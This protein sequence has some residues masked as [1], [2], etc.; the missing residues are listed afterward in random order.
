MTKKGAMN[1][2]LAEDDEND[3]SMDDDA[4]EKD[5]RNTT[6]NSVLE[7]RKKEPSIDN[8]FKVNSN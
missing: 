5:Y 2:Y 1:K 3:E 6:T 8:I 4:T 7:M